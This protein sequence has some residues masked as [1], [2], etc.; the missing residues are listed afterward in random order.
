MNLSKKPLLWIV[1]L[2]LSLLA[3]LNLVWIVKVLFYPQMVDYADGIPYSLSIGVLYKSFGTYPYVMTYYPPLYYVLFDAFRPFVYSNALPYLY[4]RLLNFVAEVVA[5]GLIYLI[6]VK[7]VRVGKFKALLAPATFFSFYFVYGPIS[8]SNPEIFEIIFDLLTVFALSS[9]TRGAAFLA[10]LALSI[11]FL[12][13]QTAAL[14]LIPILIYFVIIKDKKG[15]LKFLIA[16]AVVAVPAVVW[17]NSVTYG[18]FFFSVFTVPAITPYSFRYLV[19]MWVYFAICAPFL[20]ILLIAINRRN[21]RENLLLSLVL[22][23]GLLFTLDLGKWGSNFTYF[24]LPLSVACIL[25]VAN[26]ENVFGRNASGK[27][28]IKALA[29]FWI[30]LFPSFML[31]YG[32]VSSMP[33]VSQGYAKQVDLLRS[34]SGNVLVEYPGLALEANKSLLFEPSIFWVMQQNGLWND[35]SIVQ[36]V[37]MQKFAVIAFNM[38]GRFSLY[39]NLTDAINGSYFEE[40]DISGMQVYLPK[41]R[42]G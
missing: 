21:V 19:Y 37:R 24:M 31:V 40:A 17:L 27:T 28:S 30:L 26:I 12:F 20:A 41:P 11:A 34:L 16:F 15:A 23:F 25:A 42:N 39:P 18:R 36:D 14:L 9:K 2:V 33:Q 4:E 22:I 10:G 5:C 13:K 35:S 32:V 3:V 7:V 8:F 6:S 29:V 1:I 38:G